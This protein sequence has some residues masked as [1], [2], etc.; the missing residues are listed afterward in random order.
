VTRGDV[1]PGDLFVFYGLLKQGAAG[2]PAALDLAGAGT[3]GAPCHF[4]GA[5]Y[6]LGGFPGVVDGDGLC[7]GV[8]WQVRDAGVVPAM[9]AFEDVTDDPAT[10]LYVRV[11]VGLFDAAGAPTGE[12]AWIYWYN[13]PVEGLP[14]V[15]DGNWPLDAGKTRK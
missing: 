15:P 2:A 7:H 8:R 9:D 6:D 4:K 3:F 1:S 14:R 5:M 13:R 11:R 10:S 12:Q